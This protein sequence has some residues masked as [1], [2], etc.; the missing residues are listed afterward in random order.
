M[1]IRALVNESEVLKVEIKTRASQ[2]KGLRRRLKE[3][4]GRIVDYL[5]EKEQPGVKYEGKAVYIEEKERRKPKKQRDRVE[6]SLGVLRKHGID[7]PEE[8]L[9]ELNNARRGSPE[10]LRKLKFGKLKKKR[11]RGKNRIQD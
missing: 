7:N 1:S 10:P 2:L 5:D 3:V 6:D 9:S 4:E 8:V 11:G